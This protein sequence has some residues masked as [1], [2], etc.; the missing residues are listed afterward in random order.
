MMLALPRFHYGVAL[1]GASHIGNVRKN[2][3]DAWRVDMDVG[4]LAVADG[5]GGHAA[6]EVAATLG[7][8]SLIAA[9]GRPEAT[10]CFDTYLSGPT[11]EARRQVFGLLR[12]A[13]QQAHE[14][15]LKEAERDKSRRGMGCTLEAA[16]LLGEA[17]FVVHVGDSR[18][19][20]ARP[21]AVVQVTHDHTIEG[22]RLA[23]GLRT[24]SERPTGR[25]ALI[26]AV[27]QREGPRIDEIFVDLAEG[28]RLMLCTDGVHGL[29]EGEAEIAR[30]VRTGT[31]S[32]AVHKLITAALEA[33]GKDNATVVIADVGSRRARAAY[34]GGQRARDL[35]LAS[36]CFLLTELAHQ[37]QARLLSVS[38]ETEF[39]AGDRIP[40]FF[41]EDRVAYIVLEGEA[42]TPEGWTLGPSAVLYPESLAGAGRGTMFSNALLP[43]RALRIRYDDFREV[44]RGDIVLS[45]QLYERLARALAQRF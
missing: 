40:R 23:S 21:S 11:L 19:Y 12:W 6:G 25:D 34:D 26:S 20:V 4:I 32:D 28:D 45:A 17:A 9:V 3:E 22:S 1:A 35:T 13:A 16:L 43:V 42:S 29:I 38:V 8:D 2:N 39:A 37:A 31:P 27:G 18:T 10:Q 33:G 44:C 41:T 14:S 36:N 7:L 5:M 30:L 24:P 15:V